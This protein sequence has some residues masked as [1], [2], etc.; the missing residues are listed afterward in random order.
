MF[1][2]AFYLLLFFSEEILPFLSFPSLDSTL[3]YLFFF[4]SFFIQSDFFL[5]FP[6]FGL[7]S[8]FS[9][10]FQTNAISVVSQG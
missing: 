1:I 2:F 9:F 8:F 3:F 7:F 4:V 6:Y 10:V 5:P